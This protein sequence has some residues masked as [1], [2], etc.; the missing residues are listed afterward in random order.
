MKYSQSD[1]KPPSYKHA[2]IK[3]NR[4]VCK[5]LAIRKRK[6]KMTRMQSFSSPREKVENPLLSD[7]FRPFL[8]EK[9]KNSAKNLQNQKICVHLHPLSEKA[10]A[11]VR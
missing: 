1:E 9:I 2:N 10:T 8:L 5:V 11:L 3:I 4:L 7:S 6:L